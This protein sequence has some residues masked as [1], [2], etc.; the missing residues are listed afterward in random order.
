MISTYPAEPSDRATPVREEGMPGFEE[1][2][3]GRLA[4]TDR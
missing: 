3:P 2:V 1:G 4:R